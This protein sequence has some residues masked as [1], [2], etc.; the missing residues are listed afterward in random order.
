MKLPEEGTNEMSKDWFDWTALNVIMQGP[1]GTKRLNLAVLLLFAN[2]LKN[3]LITFL[4]LFEYGFSG[5]I[6]INSQE[7]E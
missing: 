1:K 4:Y 2:F 3:G 6:L 5:M 7:M